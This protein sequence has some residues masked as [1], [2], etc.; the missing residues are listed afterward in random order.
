[1]TEAIFL[2]FLHVDELWEA[3]FQDALAPEKR[4]K[5][6]AYANLAVQWFRHLFEFR[7]KINPRQ[8]YCVNYRDL[9][10]DPK[11][12]IEG[13]Y[14]HFGWTMSE[15]FRGELVRATQQQRQFKSKHKYT[16]EEFGLSKEWIQSELGGMMDH[17]AL[18]R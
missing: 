9:V 10:R 11:A 5:L 13:A 6:M 7:R 2:L 8:Y 15:A 18:P 12:A 1:V 4:R 16:L 17:Y 14:G 3:G